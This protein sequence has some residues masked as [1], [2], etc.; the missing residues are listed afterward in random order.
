MSTT[1]KLIH[2]TRDEFGE[3]KVIESSGERS[4]Y[5]ASDNKQ[6][7]MQLYSPLYLC[8]SYTRAMMTPLLFRDP[9][10]NVLL[11]GLGGGSLAKYLH[12]KF[13][14]CHIDIVE[15]RQKVYQLAVEHFHL[16]QSSRLSIHIEDI[17]KFLDRHKESQH[18]YDYILIDAFCEKGLASSV[19]STEFIPQIFNQLN[20]QGILSINLWSD[21][22]HTCDDVI[23]TLTL[24]FNNN[25]LKLP[26]DKNENVIYLAA[27]GNLMDLSHKLIKERA[28]Q[29]TSDTG[30]EFNYF[31]KILNNNNSN[32][33]FKSFF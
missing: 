21:D 27:K 7:S 31:L 4:L 17:Y 25:V 28:H 13:P 3:I 29:L 30:I 11:V 10:E 23:S 20:H 14:E 15:Q 12:H 1:E 18:H 24:A 6:S 16:P 8:L 9:P 22:D 5:F 19:T 2:H 26:V 32:S 33:W